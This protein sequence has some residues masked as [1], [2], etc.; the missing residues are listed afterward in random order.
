MDRNQFIKKWN[1][2]FEDREQKLEFAQEMKSDLDKVIKHELSNTMS[3][4]LTIFKHQDG[5]EILK[6]NIVFVLIDP[7]PDR[8]E[9]TIKEYLEISDNV[10]EAELERAK[11]RAERIIRFIKQPNT[12]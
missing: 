1:V 3:K 8:K 12:Q 9:I 4:K 7:Q 10:S 11:S 6:A 2:G 5:H